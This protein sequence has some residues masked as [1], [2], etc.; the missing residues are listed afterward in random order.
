M[1]V[2]IRDVGRSDTTGLARGT[3]PISKWMPTAITMIDLLY[4][5]LVGLRGLGQWRRL[6]LLIPSTA[7]ERAFHLIP[8]RVQDRS[9]QPSGIR[10]A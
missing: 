10:K 8:T 3:A 1:R 2:P 6:A 9:G 4:H 7:C 5:S